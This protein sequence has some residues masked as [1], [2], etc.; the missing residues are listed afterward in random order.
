MMRLTYRV[1]AALALMAA[2]GV[3][4]VDMLALFHEAEKF[5]PILSAARASRLAA[6][7]KRVQGEA[8]LKPSV[9][10]SGSANQNFGNQTYY[11]PTETSQ[12]LKYNQWGVALNASL[13]LYRP[14]NNYQATQSSALTEQGDLQLELSEQNLILRVAKA[15]TDRRIAEESLDVLYVHKN[16]IEQQLTLAKKNFK[17]G[18]AT[19]VDTHEA[20]ARYDQMEAQLSATKLDVDNKKLSLENIVGHTVPQIQRLNPLKTQSLKFPTINEWLE[21]AQQH[22]VLKL[23]EKNAEIARLEYKKSQSALNPTVDL[24]S[25]L[26]LNKAQGPDTI[27][28]H[29]RQ[30]LATVGIQINYPLYQ[31]G[32]LSSQARE[33]AAL[34]DKALDELHSRRID[35][36]QSLQEAWNAVQSL[37]AQMIAL[38]QSVISSGSVL[39]S[40]QKGQEVG[41]RTN[42]DVLNAQQLKSQSER[43]YAKA[44]YDYVMAIIKLYAA[45]GILDLS[46]LTAV[47]QNFLP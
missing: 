46:A 43:D 47:N 16:A 20:Q 2:S 22:P 11:L 40:S 24:A 10:L 21:I 12:S 17:I 45:A 26:G 5:D 28:T 23:A 14:A 6:Q 34:Y 8:L 4:A 31:G 3:Y 1:L 29:Y 32:A 42:L 19:I 18:N 44:R 27:Y 37:K 7:E 30:R 15:Y 25:Q 39:K 36:I 35:I 9:G 41:V 13:P 33:T 38:Q